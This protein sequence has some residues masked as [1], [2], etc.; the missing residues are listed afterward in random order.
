M[1][2]TITSTVSGNELESSDDNTGF[3]Q[4]PVTSLTTV[5]ST[6]SS[7]SSSTALPSDMTDIALTYDYFPTQPANISLP[8]AVMGSKKR[9]FDPEWYRQYNWL[10][11]S[12]EKDAAFFFACRFF[13]SAAVCWSRPEPTYTSIGFR[14]WKHATG[15][16]GALAKHNN[17]TK[18]VTTASCERSFSALKGIKNLPEVNN[19]RR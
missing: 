3:S 7:A 19:D 13:S 16:T 10:E 14:N 12:I 2:S 8:A 11:Y 4:T 5:T 15:T 1:C 17:T 18:V 6:H 9:S